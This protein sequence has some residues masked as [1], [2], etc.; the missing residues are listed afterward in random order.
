[1]AGIYVHIPYCKSKC[2]YCDFYSIIDSGNHWRF[3]KAV[4]REAELRAGYLAD[5]KVTTVYFGGGTP[6][7]FSTAELG[8]LLEGLR[9]VFTIDEKAEVTIEVNPDDANFQ[10]LKDTK[11]SG[12]NRLSLG[13]Q[14]WNEDILKMLNR[15]HTVKQSE[16]ALVNSVKA[17]FENISV[18]LIYGIPGYE[19]E[20]WKNDLDITLKFDIKH[21]SAYHL[22]IEPGT[23]FGKMKKSGKLIETDE[24][25]SNEQF[26]I[27]V[28]K[29]A[30]AEFVQYEISNFAREG[31]FSVHNCNYWRQVPYLGLGP[32]AHSYNRLSRQ[33]NIR[34]VEKYISSL[35]SNKTCFR[36]EELDLKTRFNEYIMTSLRT[37]WGIDLDHVEKNFEKE[38]SDYLTNLSKKFVNYGLVR[39]HD[40]HMVLTGT[41]KMIADNIISELMMVE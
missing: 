21:I 2:N 40:R 26:N 39:M 22:T 41:G 29:T 5:E 9:R 33:W 18:D 4:L 7:V 8:K 14:T 13:L 19:T 38:G 30:E 27:L 16:K 3:I 31:W 37:I 28:E 10:W 36:Q 24:E 34:D 20:S 23:V 15:R 11:I 32:S 35:E 12:F 1:M 6:S 17:G 25:M